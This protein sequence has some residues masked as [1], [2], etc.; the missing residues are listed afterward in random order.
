MRKTGFG[1][2]FVLAA[3]LLVHSFA[4]AA[5][6]APAIDA[7]GNV[8]AAS[9]TSPGILTT[10]AQTIAGA[11][12]FTGTASFSAI[13]VTT[14]AASAVTATGALKGGTLTIG[15]V[16]G[17]QIDASYLLTTSK[18]FTSITAGDCATDHAVAF[19]YATLGQTC[20]LGYSSAP[21]AG[22]V[23]D[24]FVSGAGTVTVRACAS[25]GATAVDPADRVYTVRC[26][27]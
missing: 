1:L 21:E 2:A 19:G 16:T 24:A 5:P 11:K 17:S 15:G 27:K 12:N 18:D 9:A 6:P 3:A 13:N 10:G 4:S 7:S 14:V 26:F 20:I 25:K 22:L 8:R 23:A